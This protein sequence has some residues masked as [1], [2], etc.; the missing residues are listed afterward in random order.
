MKAHVRLI[1]F[2]LAT[3]VVCIACA[4]QRS[5]DELSARVTKLEAKRTADKAA[6]TTAIDAAETARLDCRLTA[7]NKFNEWLQ[8]NGTPIKGKPGIFNASAEGIKQARTEQSRADE[9]CQREYE[10][11]IQVAKL[12]YAE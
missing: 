9:N 7:E 10:D 6:L 4:T 11:A 1:V 2:A 5:V 3:V 12:K 8:N